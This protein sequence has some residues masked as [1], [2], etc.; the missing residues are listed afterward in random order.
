M[1]AVAAVTL[2]LLVCCS[3][4]VKFASYIIVMLLIRSFKFKFGFRFLGT[5]EINDEIL[6]AII[7]TLYMYIRFFH[8]KL[9]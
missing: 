6:N 3:V 8:S 4:Y 7:H 2:I 9:G 5:W 1:W